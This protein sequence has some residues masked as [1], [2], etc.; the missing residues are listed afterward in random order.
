METISSFVNLHWFLGFL[1]ALILGTGFAFS[2]TRAKWPA[3]ALS[4]AL[5]T[6]ILIAKFS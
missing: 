1:A 6:I 3:L 4:L 5:V 2:G